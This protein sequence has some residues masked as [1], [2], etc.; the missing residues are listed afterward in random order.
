MSSFCIVELGVRRRKY[1]VDRRAYRRDPEAPVTAWASCVLRSNSPAD[2]SRSS[3]TVDVELRSTL[4]ALRRSRAAV[5]D[6]L[7]LPRRRRPAHRPSTSHYDGRHRRFLRRRSGLSPW[8]V[9]SSTTIA[10]CKRAAKDE[11]WN[12]A[13][14]VPGVALLLMFAA[15]AT[16]CW[17]NRARGDAPASRADRRPGGDGVQARTSISTLS[18]RCCTAGESPP[19]AAQHRDVASGERTDWQADRE[20]MGVM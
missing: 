10:V 1:R 14:V 18:I 20:S 6:D 5:E 7:Q 4:G 9:E 8:D 3:R 11:A 13:T 12:A 16:R 17:C 2:R 15:L 19:N